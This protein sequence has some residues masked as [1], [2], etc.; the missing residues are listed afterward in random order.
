MQYRQFCKRA[1]HIIKQGRSY[2]NTLSNVANLLSVTKTTDYSTESSL[3][4]II[5]L[6]SDTLKDAFIH[7]GENI[8]D[9]PD[10]KNQTVT[11]DIARR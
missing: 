4:A 6:S 1:A 11:V 9:L 2:D 5:P 7:L 10:Q 8:S 3:Q